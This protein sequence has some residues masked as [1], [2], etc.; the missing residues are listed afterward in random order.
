MRT[1][2]ALAYGDAD[3]L[4]RLRDAGL[5]VRERRDDDGTLL[6]YAVALPGDRADG[7]TRPV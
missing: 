6:G 5:R 7:G 2:A 1:A 3:F 4:E